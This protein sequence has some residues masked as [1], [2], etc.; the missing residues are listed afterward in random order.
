[1]KRF[2]PEALGIN[3]AKTAADAG[4]P[5]HFPALNNPERVAILLIN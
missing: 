3:V 1:M 5:I 4:M 2:A